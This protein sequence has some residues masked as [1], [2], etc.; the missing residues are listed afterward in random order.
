MVSLHFL[1]GR[2]AQDR[3]SSSA[4]FSESFSEFTCCDHTEEI[5]KLPS[6]NP[7][8]SKISQREL[9]LRRNLNWDG[10]LH[11]PLG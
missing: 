11:S 3:C 9:Y 8:E 4:T 2:K 10:F 7:D 6:V 1:S 5:R